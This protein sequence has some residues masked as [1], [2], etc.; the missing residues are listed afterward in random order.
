MMPG[1]AVKN[2]LLTNVLATNV[3]VT[4]ALRMNAPPP[5]VSSRDVCRVFTADFIF[6]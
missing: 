6:H 4:N 5:V 2:I 1:I 3:L